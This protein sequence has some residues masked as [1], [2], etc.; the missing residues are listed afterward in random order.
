MIYLIKWLYAWILPPGGII[1]MLFLITAYLYYK[2][3]QGRKVLLIVTCIFYALCL[4]FFSHLLMK[5]L[6][7]S[8]TQPPGDGDVIVLLG[9]GAYAGV[10]DFDGLGQL[11]GS[12]ANRFLMA[13]RLQRILNLPIILSGGPL[14]ADEAC[15]A[16][17]E[18][19]MLLSLGV[20][21]SKIY[22]DNLSR[23]TV[24]NARFAKD[25]CGMYGWQHPVLVTSAFHMPR[26]VMLFER[27][28]LQVTP[29]VSD[30]Q[31]EEGS[32]LSAF[33]LLPRIPNFRASC[34]A[35]KVY[36]GIAAI[37]MHMQ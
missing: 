14:F 18:K 35:L 15:E 10:P 5:P 16:D 4:P 21:E 19:R 20:D 12:S 2:K 11:G 30:Y 7:N 3:S 36:A 17:I 8:Y 28:G 6:E 26:A 29:Y 24:E 34:L 9:G 32:S 33:S 23:N 31:T 1:L 13:L 25:L 22:I 27:E 37:K